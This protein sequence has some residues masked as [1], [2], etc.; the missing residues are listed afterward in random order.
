MEKGGRA[1][2][3]IT[4][5]CEE[6]SDLWL[7]DT[8]TFWE[9]AFELERVKVK[10]GTTHHQGEARSR[11]GRWISEV[12]SS[13]WDAEFWSS[14]IIEQAWGARVN[15]GKGVLAILQVPDGKTEA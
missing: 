10:M 15:R 8:K 3:S 14:D 12:F 1:S 5:W 2:N 6:E 4:N 7:N 11:Q 9:L 13:V